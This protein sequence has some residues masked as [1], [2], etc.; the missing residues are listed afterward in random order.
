MGPG[1]LPE[2]L[3][4]GDDGVERLWGFTG[5][6]FGLAI[7]KSPK[8]EHWDFFAQP[9]YCNRKRK[10]NSVPIYIFYKTSKITTFNITKSPVYNPTYHCVAH[11]HCQNGSVFVLKSIR[12]TLGQAI[13]QIVF[14]D[15]PTV[16]FTLWW[17]HGSPYGYV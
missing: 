9:L 11:L 8:N 14:C 4:G 5:T 10:A 3:C 12:S 7:G 17:S 2:P 1:L 13:R 16:R 15:S 6:V